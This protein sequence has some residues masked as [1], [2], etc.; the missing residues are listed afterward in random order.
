MDLETGP[1]HERAI[2]I[3]TR[4]AALGLLVGGAAALLAACSTPAP[5]PPTA[6]AA[7]P[8]SAATAGQ[9]T[10]APQSTTGAAP[11]GQA[12]AQAVAIMTEQVL[13]IG[14][15]YNATPTLVANRLRNVTSGG[16][17]STPAWNA[18]DWDIV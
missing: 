12:L 7:N 18:A 16:S 3:V 9:S 14:L 13:P 5:N 15:F 4:R 11:T 6:A 1:Q 8:T 2:P 17:A 10:S